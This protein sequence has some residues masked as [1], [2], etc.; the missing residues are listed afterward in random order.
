[1]FYPLNYGDRKF[2]RWHAKESG[3]SGS[4]KPFPE[5]FSIRI[6]LIP[7]LRSKSQSDTFRGMKS[8]F[9]LLTALLF[10]LPTV[11]G[12]EG[13]TTNIPPDPFGGIGEEGKAADFTLKVDRTRGAFVLDAKDGSYHPGSHFANWVWNMKLERW[14]NYYAG[15]IYDSVS[16]KLGVQLK[17]GNETPLKSY[18]PRTNALS[19]DKPLVLGS[20]YLPETGEYPVMLLTGDQSNVPA[21][22]VKGIHFSPAPESE[23]HGQSI[24]GTI[25]LDAKSATTY[26]EM[27]R[28]EPK[29]E[30][31]CLGYWKLKEDWAEWVF[32]VSAPGEFELIVHYGCGSGSEG[33]RVA[34]LLNDQ[35]VEFDV[36]DTG[37]FQSW[38]EIKLGSVDLEVK[39]ENRL[40]IVALEKKGAAIM[41]IKKVMLNPVP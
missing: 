39:G 37:G 41:D 9:L 11:Y 28:Y 24:D 32:D 4:F 33:S 19:N 30:K 7:V 29:P 34:V 6:F 23:P 13:S 10:N 1:M 15:L 40:A 18:A 31:D 26:A 17:V 22:Q 36:E 38:K 14:G 3:S 20:V 21:F 2:R 16:P 5:R 27:M 25:L 12:Q 35:T 8:T